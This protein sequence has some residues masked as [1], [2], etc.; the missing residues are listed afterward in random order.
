[1]TS[2]HDTAA[3]ATRRRH[4][5]QGLALLFALLIVTA[6]NRNSAENATPASAGFP[7]FTPTAEPAD[8]HSAP[9]ADAAGASQE[10][11]ASDVGAVPLA[12][13]PAA[14]TSVFSDL[15]TTEEA[16]SGVPAAETP[17]PAA[18]AASA[19]AT[20]V[21]ETPVATQSVTTA[22]QLD[23]ARERYRVGDY[24]AA[25]NTLLAL[26]SAV[27]SDAPL[28]MEV[29]FEL[30]R[31]YLAH[32]Q[33]VESLDA[34]DALSVDVQA[35]GAATE[36]LGLA[37]HLRA[38]ANMGLGQYDAAIA[39]YTAFLN[40]YPALSESVQQRMAEVYAAAGNTDGAVGAYRAA[41]SAAATAGDVSMQVL[42]LEYT[43]QTYTAAARHGEAAAVYDEILSIAQNPGY[44]AQIAYQAGS[45]HAAAGNE[46]VAIERWQTATAEGPTLQWGYLALVELVNRDIPFDLYQR[47]YIDLMYGAWL[48]AV[49]AYSQFLAAT[50][51]ASDT[52]YAA[53]VQELGQAYLGAQDTTNAIVQFDRVINAFSSSSAIGAAWLNKGRAQVV[54]GDSAGARRTWRTFARDY[55][56]HEL[57]PE[58]LW[59]SA[60]RALSDDLPLEAAIDFLALAE[61]FPQSSRAADALYAVGLGS[62]QQGLYGQASESFAR[63]QREYPDSR[64]FATIYWLGRSLQA[65]GKTTEANAAFQT[66]VDQAPDVYYGILANRA[67]QSLSVQNGD[68]LNQMNLVVGPASRLSGDDGSQA[69]AENW[70]KQWDLFAAVENPSQLPP[71]VANDADLVQ[72]RLLL[73]LDQRADAVDALDRVYARYSDNPVV[74]YPLSLEF[75]RIGAYRNSITSMVRLLQFSPAGLVEDAPIFL[76]KFGWPRAFDDLVT[77]EALT[78]DMDPFLFFSMIRQ[79]SLF[80]E[81]AR[82]WAA[83]QGLA[84][85]IPDTARWVA[86]QQGHP[87]W[88]NDL[89]YR[90]YINVDFGA[91]YFA[92]V[93]DYLDGNPV[94]ALV[95]YN[96]GP[97][98]S[99]AWREQAGADDALFTE[100]LTVSEPR[101]YVQLI[102]ENLYHYTRLY[103][104]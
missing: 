12:S 19:V 64:T 52:R 75:S 5:A 37:N 41:A 23:E 96:A 8:G 61:A 15:N 26:L 34:L 103:G 16:S 87:D 70:L 11:A 49:N 4:R 69:F 21:V 100:I 58:A 25:I 82:S 84:Q 86:E 40:D 68:Q 17:A 42:L 74:L 33:Y 51:P 55:P 83:A 65:E 14:S 44:R 57:A 67:L 80:E 60:N 10:L 90:P 73:E 47:G 3:I 72:A 62:Y 94:S 78:H 92:W 88:S 35:T 30:A 45:A 71:E 24:A 79:E 98:N 93:R 22:Q 95:G 48:P 2:Y 46:T 27:Q 13:A 104:Q 59:L 28:R 91:Y 20:P 6:C 53:A 39:A 99:S 9:G 77:T 7:T 36:Y 32:S 1:M 81:R 102:T 29:Q 63:L 56:Q 43:A 31:A 76:Q 97:G 85:I 54:A 101:S 38:R 89:I 66:L 50:D 18:N